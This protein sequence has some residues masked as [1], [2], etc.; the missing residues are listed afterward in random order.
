MMTPH[1]QPPAEPASPSKPVRRSKGNA[2]RRNWLTGAL[3]IGV[4]G[5]ITVMGLEVYQAELRLQE[6]LQTQAQVDAELQALQEKNQRLRE[7]LQRVT[8]PESMELK[9]KQLGF[10]YENE[11]VYQTG[12]P[13]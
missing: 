8:S 12:S 6:A 4:M 11:Q 5:F 13:H 2:L 10:T 3:V 7:T 9:A 1:R